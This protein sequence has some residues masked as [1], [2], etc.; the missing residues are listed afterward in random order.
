MIQLSQYTTNNYPFPY[1]NLKCMMKNY[2]VSL[3]LSN[4]LVH[5]QLIYNAIINPK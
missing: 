2:V 5:L 3:I 1:F 4:N